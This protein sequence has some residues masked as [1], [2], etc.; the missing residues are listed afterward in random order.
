MPQLRRRQAGF[1][2]V[3]LVMVLCVASLLFSIAVTQM[4]DYTRR[5]RVSEV[6]MATSHCKSVISE[7]YIYRESAPAP[8]NWGCE[9]ETSKTTYVGAVET[10]SNGVIRIALM[11]MDP[12][13][14]GRH[15]HLAPVRADGETALVTPNDLGQSVRAWTCGSDWLPVRNALPAGCRTDTTTFS[16]QEFAAAGGGS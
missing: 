8:G 11:N 7:N 13:L 2:V 1:N 9:H 3:E 10:S 5:A 14:N 15:V 6:V 4:R 12:L 16:S